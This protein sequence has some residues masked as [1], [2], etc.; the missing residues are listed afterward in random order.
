METK[1]VWIGGLLTSW[2]HFFVDW[3]FE[4]G[5]HFFCEVWSSN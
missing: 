3:W 2:S 4:F 1:I 5:F